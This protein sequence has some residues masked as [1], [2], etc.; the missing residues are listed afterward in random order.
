MAT[1]ILAW[2]SAI[3]GMALVPMTILSIIASQGLFSYLRDRHNEIWVT[4]GKPTVW[5]GRQSASS[6]AVR[7]F[8]TRQYLASED[9]ELHQK[10]DKARALLYAAVAIFLVFLLSLLGL[11]AV[12]A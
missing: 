9:P 2:I 8:T 7:Y 5:G 11:D 3:S 1:T 6:P 4:L 10:G 12:G